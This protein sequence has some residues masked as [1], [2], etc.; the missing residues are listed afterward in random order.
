MFSAGFVSVVGVFAASVGVVVGGGVGEALA[1]GA[2]VVCEAAGASAG[3]SPVAP[4]VLSGVA[5]ACSGVVGVVT[6]VG[7][8][9]SNTL[10]V[11]CLEI[12]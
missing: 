6:A 12:P 9:L 5:G 11:V 1:D 3:L 7:G 10:F 4:L 2:G 8:E